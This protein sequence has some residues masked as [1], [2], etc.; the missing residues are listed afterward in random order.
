MATS[1]QTLTVILSPA[2][3]EDL[4]GIWGEGSEHTETYEGFLKSGLNA[5]ATNYAEGK[6]V[7][8]IPECRYITLKR[9]RKG[10]HFVIY[11]VDE[12]LGAVNILRIFHTRMD[13][14]GNTRM[15]V[16]SRLDR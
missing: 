9:M 15:D 8:G 10:G 1:R 7:D 2:A 12:L 5:L 4:L 16:R 6:D 14:R 3:D 13:V 11:E